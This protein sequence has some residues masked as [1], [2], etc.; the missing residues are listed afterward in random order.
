VCLM[1]YS[2]G[3]H[4]AHSVVFLKDHGEFCKTRVQNAASQFDAIKTAAAA[5]SDAAR[6]MIT[7]VGTTHDALDQRIEAACAQLVET[8]QQRKQALLRK[9]QRI[10]ATKCT[11]MCAL[12]LCIPDLERPI[13]SYVGAQ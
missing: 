1:C 4:K 9:S 11:H 2:F 13:H 6:A 3:D 8:I 10:R 12:I 7:E 5:A